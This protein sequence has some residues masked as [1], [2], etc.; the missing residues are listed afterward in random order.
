MVEH[1]WGVNLMEQDLIDLEANQVEQD[2]QRIDLDPNHSR[3]VN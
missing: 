2:F 1:Y 3:N